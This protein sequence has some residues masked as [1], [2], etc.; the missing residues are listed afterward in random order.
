VRSLARRLGYVDVG[1]VPAEDSLGDEY[2]YH[3]D[4]AARAFRE[5]VEPRRAADAR[6]R[7]DP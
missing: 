1:E 6:L 7:G 5:A 3:K 4:V 2:A